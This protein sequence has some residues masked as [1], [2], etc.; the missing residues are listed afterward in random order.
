MLY[1]PVV[2]ER[3]I[4]ERQFSGGLRAGSLNFCIS[5]GGIGGILAAAVN[6]ELW[7]NAHSLKG[8]DRAACSS[9]WAELLFIRPSFAGKCSAHTMRGGL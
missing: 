2:V 8:P 6:L 3:F 5:G 7:P 9:P 4:V 1:L